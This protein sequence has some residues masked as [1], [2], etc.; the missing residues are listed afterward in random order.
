MAF[1]VKFLIIYGLWQVYTVGV[2]SRFLSSKPLKILSRIN[3]EMYLVQMVSFRVVEKLN[4]MYVFGDSG[5]GSWLSLGV[6]TALTIIGL[7]IFTQYFKWFFSLLMHY[8]V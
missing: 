6:A 1:Y 8:R 3:M 5:I 7:I 2:D 4:L